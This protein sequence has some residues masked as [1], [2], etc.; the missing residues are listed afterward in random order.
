MYFD[1]STRETAETP[2]HTRNYINS[3]EPSCRLYKIQR[4]NPKSC[5]VAMDFTT[6]YNLDDF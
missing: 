6:I 4:A 5:R 3:V 2:A 1:I